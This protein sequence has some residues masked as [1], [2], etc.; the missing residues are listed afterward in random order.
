MDLSLT[1]EQKG[2]LERVRQ[3]CD[4]EVDQAYIAGLVEQ[5]ATAKTVDDLRAIQPVKLIARAQE[6]GLRQLAVPKE[7]GGEGVC[8]GENLTRCLLSEDFGYRGNHFAARLLTKEWQTCSVIAG[9]HTTQEQKDWFF[10]KFMTKLGMCA[11]ANSEPDGSTDAHLPWDE[12]GAALKTYAQK[13][14]GEYI[15]NGEKMFSHGGAVADFTWL[16]ARTDL[17][18]P[19]SES[20]SVIW[21]LKDTPGVS[22]QLNQMVLPEIAGNFRTYFENVHVPAEQLVGTENQGNKLME[23]LLGTKMIAFSSILGQNQMLYEQLVEY[24]R[25]RVQ[26]GKPLLQHSDVAAMLGEVAISLESTRSMLYRS[27]WEIDQREIHGLPRNNAWSISNF[28]NIKKLSLLMYDVGSNI[29]GGRA[30]LS[31]NAFAHWVQHIPVFLAGGSAIH[32]DQIEVSKWY[33]H[34]TLGEPWIKN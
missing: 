21:V 18:G 4:Q 19:V 20:A 8:V 15:I 17:K 2:L 11:H 6:L 32:M 13:I 1:N 3:F 24:A 14:D 12:P 10:P 25:K 22:Y 16:L 31:D 33:N 29:Y 30:A 9:C 34:H 26:G 27:C 28:W 7:Y 23:D 5:A